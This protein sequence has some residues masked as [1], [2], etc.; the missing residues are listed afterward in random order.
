MDEPLAERIA[1][2]VFDMLTSNPLFRAY[3]AGD[4]DC[5]IIWS[6]MTVELLEARIQ[7]VMDDNKM[8]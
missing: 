2:G 4:D 3:R 1:C 7:E 8:D 5:I 6:L